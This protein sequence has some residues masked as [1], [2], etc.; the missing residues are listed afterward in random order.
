MVRWRKAWGYRESQPPLRSLWCFRDVN[1]AESTGGRLH[2]THI[3]TAGGVDI[4]R[5]ARERGLNVTAEATPHHLTIT[6][7][8]VIPGTARRGTPGVMTPGVFNTAAKV[9]PPL[10]TERDVAAVVQGLRDGVI[11]CIATDHAPHTRRDKDCSFQEAAFGISG[12]EVAL[13]SLMSLVHDGMLDM[14]TLIDRLTAGPA[15]VLGLPD[16]FPGALR[17]G[18]P[19][20]VTVFDPDAEWVV[21]SAEFVSRGKNTPLEGAA[22]RGRVMATIVD[23]SI[24]YRDEALRFV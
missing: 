14:P 8:W 1:L 16:R 19:A 15:R 24:V 22:L 21:D 17:I 12:L 2:L 5:D 18:A 13:G 7:E 6:E 4:L 23:G 3:S 10:R 11:D 20:D 9:N